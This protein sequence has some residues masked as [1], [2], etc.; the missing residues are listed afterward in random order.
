MEISK[1]VRNSREYAITVFV[2]NISSIL[3]VGSIT[4]EKGLLTYLDRVNT[5]YEDN[6]VTVIFAQEM[7][8]PY[9]DV[10]SNSGPRLTSL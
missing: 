7:K 8:H 3:S 5:M 2:M 1:C 10:N 4:Y 9:S 6:S